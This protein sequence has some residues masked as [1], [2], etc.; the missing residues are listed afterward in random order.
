MEACNRHKQTCDELVKYTFSREKYSKSKS[1]FDRIEEFYN[2]L[3]KK[4][5]TYILYNKFIPIVD[6]EDEKYDP[7]ECAFG[8]EAMLKKLKLKTIKR[9]YKL[10]QNMCL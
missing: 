8:F 1:I 4:Q 9:N 10:H 5:K 3:I 6:N 2:N 7:Y